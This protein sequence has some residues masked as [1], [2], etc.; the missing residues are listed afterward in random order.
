MKIANLIV[1]WIFGIMFIA[2]GALKFLN[3]D[4]MSAEIFARAGYPSWLYYGVAAFELGGGIL[5]LIP[6][7]SRIGAAM[8]CVVMFGAIGTHIILKDN[9]GHMIAPILI[10]MFLGLKIVNVKK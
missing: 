4:A 1:T 10:I 6:K 2:T 5:L 3:M 7:Q 9:L 8:L